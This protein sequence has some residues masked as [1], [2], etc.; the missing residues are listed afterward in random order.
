[1]HYKVRRG[2]LHYRSARV[3]MPSS[4]GANPSLVP[5]TAERMAASHSQGRVLVRRYTRA[6]VVFVV[7]AF[8]LA[9]LV[10]LPLWL[11]PGLAHPQFGLIAAAIMFT[12]GLAAVAVVLAIEKPEL[13]LHALGLWPLGR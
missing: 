1:P 13:P 12:P 5:M 6:V 2:E 3:A 7:L 11:G 9:W 4:I 8:V 10:A